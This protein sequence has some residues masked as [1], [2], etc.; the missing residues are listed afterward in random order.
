MRL[1]Y[2]FRI[3][4]GSVEATDGPHLVG[5]RR[6]WGYHGNVKECHCHGK[7]IMMIEIQSFLLVQESNPSAFLV[8]QPKMKS[9]DT[10]N[11]IGFKRGVHRGFH[12]RSTRV[13]HPHFLRGIPIDPLL[14]ICPP[15]QKKVQLPQ[16]KQIHPLGRIVNYWP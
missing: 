14:L 12:T 5:I 9:H 11:F 13:N 16:K 8:D 1:I 15:P 7:M 3:D 2:G 6:S 10:A 4:V